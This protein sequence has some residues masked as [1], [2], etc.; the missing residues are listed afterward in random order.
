MNTNESSETKNQGQQTAEQPDLK[1]QVIHNLHRLRTSVKW[2]LIGIIT[3]LVVGAVGIAFSY[4]MSAATTM[5][6]I[7]PWLLYFLP[8]AGV[9]IVSWYYL[10]KGKHDKGTNLVI[11]AIH[12]GEEVPLRMAPRIF[13]ATVLTH[14]CGGSAG[15]EGAALQIGASIGNH[16]GNVFHFNENDKRVMIMCGMSACFSALFGT[17]MAAA[18]FSMEVISVGVM[19]Y[20]ALVPCVIASFV[21]HSLAA[22]CGVGWESFPVTD[23]PAFTIKSACITGILAILCA[24]LS[25]IFC[26]LLHQTAHFFRKR[27]PNH[28]L[29]TIVGGCIII[30]LTL[31]V[32]NRDY[33]GA[34]MD[35]IARCFETGTVFPGAFLLKMIFTAITL[36]TCYKGGEIVPTF[37]VGATFGCLFSMITGF[38]SPL[39]IAVG[40]G[41]LFCG[42]TNSPIASLLICFE[43]FG[44]EGMPYYLLAIALSYMFSGYYGL[45]SSQ[46]I[47][48]S[49][50][51]TTYI[52]RKAQ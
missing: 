27:V 26:F 6:N 52:D 30:I 29:R 50:F 13:I 24:V 20:A 41:S 36:G 51:K 32:G 3:G 48:Y 37:Y 38:S 12:S 35:V 49:K 5:R 31:L 11:S 33:N 16:I 15:R 28:Y 44:Y 39:C 10:F 23:L 21:A 43:L 25:V 22:I 19:Y 2:I 1:R 40:M 18:I 7:Y 47:L 42:V 45:Y 8:I 46:K 9:L 34:G 17:P 4:A 14:L